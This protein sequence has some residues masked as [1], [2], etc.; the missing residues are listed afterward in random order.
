MDSQIARALDIVNSQIVES[1]S[2]CIAQDRIHILSH[3]RW[4]ASVQSVEKITGVTVPTNMAAKLSTFIVPSPSVLSESSCFINV[5]YI[6]V[7]RLFLGDP[8]NRLR[9]LANSLQLS[10]RNVVGVAFPTH[11][12]E[13]HH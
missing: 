5:A 12:E 8:D 10:V 2:I 1:I 4:W 3:I 13:K 7:V 6:N 11:V 9:L